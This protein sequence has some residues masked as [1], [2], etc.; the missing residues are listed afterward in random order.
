MNT[1]MMCVIQLSIE[2][3]MIKFWASTFD[4]LNGLVRNCY[5]NIHTIVLIFIVGCHNGG[6]ATPAAIDKNHS[7]SI[8]QS[9]NH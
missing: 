1:K 8:R 5:Q 3:R 4:L 6:A 2:K 7:P 9:R